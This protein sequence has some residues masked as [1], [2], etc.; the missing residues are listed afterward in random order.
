MRPPKYRKHSSRDLGFVEFRGG[1]HYFPGR[2]NSAESKEA[3]RTFLRER[4]FAKESAEHPPPSAVSVSFLILQFLQHAAK[5][6]GEKS[7]GEF[8]NL[9]G[10][11]LPFNAI[12]GDESAATFGPLKLEEYRSKL[13]KSD[14]ARGYV[15][16]IVGRIKRCFRWGVAKQII[17]AEVYHGLQ[18]LMPLQ[19][20]YTEA[21]ETPAKKPVPWEHVKPIL[22]ELSPM[23][24]AMVHFHWLVGCRSKSMCMAMPSQFTKDGDLLLWRPRHKTERKKELILPIGPQAQ[25]LLAPYMKGRKPDEYL[26]D[27]RKQRRNRRYNK[28]YSSG[29]YA[30]AVR[31]A[32][33]RVNKDRDEKDKIPHWSPHRLRHSKGTA[34]RN[35]HGIE[36]EQAMLGHSSLK[37]SEIYSAARLDLA[38]RIARETG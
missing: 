21:R 5:Y 22:K 3:C 15:N 32:I 17:P 2:Y 9:R 28:M 23:V 38:K 10:S 37:A 6:Y 24:A 20:G 35:A 19:E 33:E 36:A 30:Y 7:R 31:R 16:Q 4:V 34:V 12:C 1:R 25:K 29:S 26:F 11:L 13:V 8:E 27:P 18:A 14:K